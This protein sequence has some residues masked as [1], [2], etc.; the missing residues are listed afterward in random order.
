M[1]TQVERKCVVLLLAITGT[2]RY[3]I[4]KKKSPLKGPKRQGRGKLVLSADEGKVEATQDHLCHNDVDLFFLPES[5]PPTPEL[6]S[7]KLAQPAPAHQKS[8]PADASSTHR[9]NANNHRKTG[10]PPARRGRLGRNQYTRDLPL[11]GEGNGSP[12]RDHSNDANGQGGSPP[13]GVRAAYNAVNGE[14]GRSS[15]PKYHNPT[16]TTMNEMKRRVAA[17]L[18]FVNRMQNERH[19]QRSSATSSDKDGKGGSTPNGALGANAVTISSGLAQA[20]EAGLSDTPSHITERHFTQ[21]AAS[22]MMET[23]TRELVQWQTLYGKH[24]ER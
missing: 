16:R 13:Y 14:S 11:N 1:A 10:R 6:S 5:P 19:S 18:E 22:E 17:I 8:N 4:V 2:R 24:G 21:M 3:E 9:P 23:L 12:T 7:A 20:V 15:K